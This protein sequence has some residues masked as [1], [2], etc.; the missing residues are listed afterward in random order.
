M[1]IFPGIAKV[2]NIKIPGQKVKAPTLQGLL[3][4][5][6]CV[7]LWK[8]WSKQNVQCLFLHSGGRGRHLTIFYTPKLSFKKV[9]IE[10][11]GAVI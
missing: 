8:Y 7:Y 11:E 5:W 6:K 1:M 3:L 10:I 2:Y 4:R 9:I